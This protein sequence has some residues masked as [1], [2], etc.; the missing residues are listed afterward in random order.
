MKKYLIIDVTKLTKFFRKKNYR[1]YFLVDIIEQ[2]S[3]GKVKVNL[4]YD[5]KHFP[6]Y[7]A[8]YIG[9]TIVELKDIEEANSSLY[10]KEHNPFNFIY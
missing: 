7:W 5:D 2:L 1:G 6:Y 10:K 8:N 3:F 9:T 4:F